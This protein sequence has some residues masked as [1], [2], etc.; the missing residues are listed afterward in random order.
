[1]SKLLVVELSFGNDPKWPS[2]HDHLGSIGGIQGSNS[3]ESNYEF[4]QWIE[5]ADATRGG[6]EEVKGKGG[7][8]P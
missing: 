8:D 6:L 2:I 7:S 4:C 5:P 1:M 3:H